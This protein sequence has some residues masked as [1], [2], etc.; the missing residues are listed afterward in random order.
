MPAIS[1]NTPDLSRSPPWETSGQW[2]VC[3][4]AA[5]AVPAASVPPG[6]PIGAVLGQVTATGAYTLCDPAVSPADGSQVPVAILASQASAGPPASPATVYP[7]G[8][9]NTARLFYSANWT[10]PLLMAALASAGIQTRTPRH[11]LF[12]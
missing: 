12:R 7:A 10:L 5:T 4:G 3:E 6:L 1:G 8:T 11:G 2:L 9:F